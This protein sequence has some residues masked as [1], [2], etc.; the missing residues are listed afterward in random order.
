MSVSAIGYYGPT[1][2]DSVAEDAP[3]GQGF[4]STSVVEWEQALHGF[5]TD[6][7]AHTMLRLGIVLDRRSGAL[8]K[9]LQT[10]PFRIL[11]ILG[12]GKQL[13]SWIH[14]EDACRMILFA[15]KDKRSDI[16]N[17]VAPHPEAQKVLTRN[18]RKLL[19]GP[20]LLMPVPVFGLRLIFGEM[21]DTILTNQ[22]ISAQKIM[23]AGF[24]FQFPDLEGA[25]ADLLKS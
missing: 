25:L 14:R 17:S 9:L 12:N 5:Q 7:I 21:A 22:N 11:G 4:L 23:D 6:T 16:Y 20:Y 3:P 24:V 10:A 15:L 13:Y 8:P 18:A 2:M 1:G 19:R